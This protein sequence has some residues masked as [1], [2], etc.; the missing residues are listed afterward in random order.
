MLCCSLQLYGGSFN[1]IRNGLPPIGIDVTMVDMFDMNQIQ[2][3]LKPNTKLVWFEVCTNPH[4]M[5]AD[6]AQ[7]V[8]LIKGYNSNIIVGTDNTF[9]SPWTF[10]RIFY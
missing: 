2:E 5:V 10:V 1:L 3:A 6:V 4:C 8:K 7:I 9:L